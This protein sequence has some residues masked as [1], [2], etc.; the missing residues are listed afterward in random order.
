VISRLQRER[1]WGDRG[2]GCSRS[3]NQ[4][5]L[6]YEHVSCKVEG[7]FVRFFSLF[8]LRFPDLECFDCCSKVNWSSICCRLSDHVVGI[9]LSISFS[10]LSWLLVFKQHATTHLDWRQS[11][12][13]LLHHVIRTQVQWACAVIPR[14]ATSVQKKVFVCL[15][16]MRIT[17][18]YAQI[19]RGR[20]RSVWKSVL[21]CHTTSKLPKP[22]R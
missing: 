4:I 2:A 14:T 18:I 22:L 12:L 5:Y 13:T 11:F 8:Y 21:V 7:F 19:Q 9:L 20:R 10:L 15:A 16:P 1:S 17:A 6:R 3:S